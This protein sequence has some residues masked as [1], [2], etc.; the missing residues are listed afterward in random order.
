[1]TT[2]QN[3]KISIQ[4]AKAW[5]GD[6]TFERIIA[7]N[8]IIL[9]DDA[10]SSKAD[11]EEW[12]K[13]TLARLDENYSLK[14]YDHGGRCFH[15]HIENIEGLSELS[16]NLRTAYK[17]AFIL[18]YGGSSA[19][20]SLGDKKHLITTPGAKVH[21]KKELG[22][23]E[24]KDYHS[25][26][27]I[28]SHENKNVPN[29]VD[30]ELLKSLPKE[31]KAQ[32]TNYKVFGEGLLKELQEKGYL[33]NAES[34]MN[35]IFKDHADT[36]ASLKFYPETNSY[37]CFGCKASGK[38][39]DLLS[40]PKKVGGMLVVD[41][42]TENA[43]SFFELNPFFYDEG[44]N[45]WSWSFQ[46][47]CWKMVDEI[48]IMN[49]LEANLSLYGQTVKGTIKNN[50]LEAF[51]R[52]GRTNTPKTPPKTWVQF[53]DK[54]Y[55]IKTGQ[56]LPTSPKY[57]LTNPI[58]WDCEFD[59]T[60]PKIDQYFESWV[61]KD[62]VILLKEIIA[63]CMVKSYFLHRIFCFIGDGSNGKS[64]FM[65][66]IE[67]IIGEKNCTSSELDDI[68]DN[69][70]E[71]AKLYKKS[72]CLMGETNFNTMS[73]TSK[74]KKLCGGDSISYEFKN[75]TPFNDKNYA[76]LIISSNGLPQTTDKTDGFYRRWVL[77]D[78]PNKFTE[79]QDVF[80]E[81][82]EQEYRN[83]C[84]Q[85]IKMAGRLWNDRKFTNEGSIEDRKARFEAHSNP[86][87]KFIDEQCEQDVEA[88]IFKFEFRDAFVAF[89]KGNGYRHWNE[90][91]IGRYM[92]IEGFPT[93]Q[94]ANYWYSNEITP[95]RYW[96]YAGLALK[97]NKPFAHG[98]QDTQALTTY[99]LSLGPKG[100]KG[101]NSVQ[102][103]KTEKL[104]VMAI[105]NIK[106]DLLRDIAKKDLNLSNEQ[107]DALIEELLKNGKLFEPSEG[108]LR[109]VSTG[110]EGVGGL[111]SIGDSRILTHILSLL[112]ICNEIPIQ[113]CIYQT[114]QNF[115]LKNE[116]IEPILKNMLF[117]GDII[118]QPSGVIR[119][120]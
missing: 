114:S 110:N 27:E 34:M 14:V 23:P 37:F 97:A 112:D 29:K 68:M 86:L 18:K 70:F 117:K 58:P 20:I 119:K 47:K 56:I 28:Y 13:Q 78:F 53:K 64:T 49:L 103:V 65:H 33:I 5:Q 51:K 62:Q 67:K 107:F 91:E 46:N 11:A 10:C 71:T 104:I 40:P 81:I 2:N 82:P 88:H 15:I 22:F 26:D 101:V 12:L 61:G 75:K 1:M 94:K 57:F 36:Q 42:Y 76:K 85:C 4:K 72:V 100:K 54:I 21:W 25:K 43:E 89:C 7:P 116:E 98:I 24:A 48:D 118:E 108:V 106:R 77:I 63:F 93:V 3:T 17:H 74:L 9:E 8:E 92:K 120:L 87:K 16:E 44:G 66:I 45:F 99:S 6:T 83:L 90:Q 79:Q 109:A 59:G 84:G 95:K 50:Y 55:D 113:Q 111:A 32:N 73:R 69:R 19:D 30:T 38:I 41:N 39:T 52:I 31:N 60:T 96:S 105:K 35:C 115:G 80:R 102:S